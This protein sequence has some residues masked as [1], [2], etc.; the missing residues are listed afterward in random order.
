MKIKCRLHQQ[1][2]DEFHAEEAGY[3]LKIGAHRN[4]VTLSIMHGSKAVEG[5][6]QLI[7]F[8]RVLLS[9]L[10]ELPKSDA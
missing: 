5:D 10:G 2:K 6:M 7:D 8:I 1:R 3:E 9:G 4:R